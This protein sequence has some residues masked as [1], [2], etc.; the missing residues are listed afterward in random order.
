[1]QEIEEQTIQNMKN[2]LNNFIE[3]QKILP[4]KLT[5]A[6]ETISNSVKNINAKEDINNFILQ[7]KTQDKVVYGNIFKKNFFIIN[8]SNL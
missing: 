5:N 2:W 8:F 4:P 3:S 1:M 6:Y 7:N